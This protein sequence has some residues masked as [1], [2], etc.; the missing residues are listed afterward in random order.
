MSMVR[1]WLVLSAVS[2]SALA[3]TNAPEVRKFSLEDCIQSALQKNLDLQIARYNVPL[4]SLTLQGS[5][6]GY[7]PSFT[8]GGVQS[9]NSE[10]GSFDASLGTVTFGQAS[11]DNA[12]NSSLGGLM[13][14]G[15]S[16]KLSGNVSESYG[17]FGPNAM[18]FDNS[19]GS[20]ERRVGK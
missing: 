20:E 10:P 3:Q 17:N 15:L 6:A 8:I 13:P 4:A 18:P 11:Y 12:F 5:Y 7:D 19:S 16:Y 14:W 9:Y 2:V 1:I